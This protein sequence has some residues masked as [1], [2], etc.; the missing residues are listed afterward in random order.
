LVSVLVVRNSGDAIDK[1][2]QIMTS[3]AKSGPIP[4]LN[5]RITRRDSASVSARL[6]AV[7]VMRLLLL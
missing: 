3:A 5:W 7:E 1:A 4:L 6:A 2:I